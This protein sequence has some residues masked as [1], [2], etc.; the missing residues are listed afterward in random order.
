MSLE[1]AGGRTFSDAWYR[2]AQVR[3]RLRT[4]VVAHRQLWQGQAW[5]VLR[6]KFSHEWYR[7][8]VDAYAFLCELEGAP[9]VDAAW[10]RTV[11]R[12]ANAALTQEE[13]VQLLGQ[14]N[15]SNLLV[16]DR[17][18]SQDTQFERLRKRKARELK[19]RLMGFLAIKIPL[20]DPDRA[21]ERALPL[22]RRIYGPVGLA[23][24]L[25]LVLL[26]LKLVIDDSDMLWHQSSGLLAPANL[27]LL[28]LGFLMAKSLHELSHAA[29]CKLFGGEVHKLGVMLLLF[30]PI[31]YVDATS[32]WGFRSRAQR[33][34]VGASGVVAELGLA[35]VAAIV[36][37]NTAPGTLNALAFDIMFVASVSTLIFNLN[38]LLRFDGYHILMDM[39]DI[40]NLFQRS[41]EQL[42]YLAERHILRLPN[43]QTAA[44]T[45][46]EAVLLPVYGVASLLYWVF[47]MT[48]IVV[49]IASEYLDLGVAL[50][51]IL[52]ITSVIWPL[53]KF[54]KYLVSDPRLSTRRGQA[55]AITLGILTLV[56]GVLAGVPV[57]DQ[58]RTAGVVEAD[59][60]RQLHA[61]TEGILQALLARPGARVRAG[62][63]LVQLVHPELAYEIQ[64]ALR[65]RE[66]LAS[67]EIQAIARASADLSSIERQIQTVEQN[68]AVLYRRREA[69]VLRA[70]IDGVW[71]AS[72][73]D[74]GLGQWIGRGASLGTIVNEEHWRFVAVLPQVGSH[75]V[76]ANISQAEVR[77]RGQEDKRLSLTALSVMP[78]E[79]GMLPARALGMAG[80]GAIAVSASDPHGV[81]AAE[82]FFRVEAQFYAQA[83]GQ[84]SL[85]HGG[86]GTLRLTLPSSPLAVQWE[87]RVRQFL[88][89]RFRV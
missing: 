85:R 47:L 45:N 50:A 69:L 6:D 37:A 54:A 36:W 63:P 4:S 67:Q 76:G 27:V 89:R 75:V 64:A 40:P 28:Y 31:P 55:V 20:F 60:S 51:V 2:V 11:E 13:V 21:L 42:R 84:A 80:G 87:R 46:S 78:F 49:F 73:L 9:S 30:A 3:T 79:Q 23:L 83:A 82:P 12:D 56:L 61:E 7:V 5:M 86:I 88:Q 62:E 15:L 53:I 26:G 48:T 33:V 16:Y 44:R 39:L 72:E 38:P 24:Y 32:A 71:S 22:I 1:Q 10:S 29:V 66:Q 57:P 34:M 19:A 59:K 8:S 17:G 25:A 68:L 41:R 58:L 74:A 81:V 65:Y 70:P 35:A 52:V 18:E 14:L 43:A 77:L